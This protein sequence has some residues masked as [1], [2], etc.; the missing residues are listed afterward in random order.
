MKPPWDHSAQSSS[1]LEAL[2][3][4]VM[5]FVAILGLCLAAIFSLVNGAQYEQ[6][7]LAASPPPQSRPE[8]ADPEPVRT[9]ERPQ[10]PEELAETAVT[11]VQTLAVEE[12]AP[13]EPE[14]GF[15]LEFESGDALRTLLA[16]GRIQL[17][18]MADGR[19]NRYRPEAGFQQSDAPPSWYRMDA[20]TV[21]GRI[22]LQAGGLYAG[23]IEWG[24]TLPG[25]TAA[26][27]GR[28]MAG[29][30]GGNLLIGAEAQVR[31]VESVQQGR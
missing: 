28:L 25:E 7:E 6:A 17:F 2:Q 21:P 4:D 15:T 13:A 14:E 23:S 11:E 31:L 27:I 19:F 12:P 8:P 18:A 3:T 29:R 16:A 9:P 1:E 26:D 24:V 30:D 20:A 22:R 10:R 5:R